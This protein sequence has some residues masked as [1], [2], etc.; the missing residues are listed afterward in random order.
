MAGRPRTFDRDAALMV[1]VDQFWTTG[2]D[3]TTISCLTRAM[4]VTP[5]SLYAAFGDKD[6]LF[7]EAAATYVRHMDE[8][9]DIAFERRTAGEAIA[10]L[11]RITAEAHTAA[12]SPPG[13]FV[14]SEPRLVSQREALRQ[15]I[16]ARLEQGLADG[17]L[18]A[19]AHP[20]QLASFLMAVMHGMSALAR[21]GGTIDDV[22]AVAAIAMTPFSMSA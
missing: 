7:A 4:G 8:G 2:Y 11:L 14:L 1:A 9:V 3:E 18:P 16:K 5:P 13:C 6:A 10:E 17:D 12:G 19:A 15:R 22:A 21:D 20:D